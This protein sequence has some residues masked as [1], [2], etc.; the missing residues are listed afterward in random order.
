MIMLNIIRS[1]LDRNLLGLTTCPVTKLRKNL[2]QIWALILEYWQSC[3]CSDVLHLD[4]N[5]LGLRTCPVTKLRKHLGQIWALIL[6]YRQSCCCS[7][8]LPFNL[9]LIICTIAV[10]IL[11][12]SF[13]PGLHMVG[14][15]A[16]HAYDDA[17]KRILMLPTYS[18]KIFLANYQNL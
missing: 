5:L 16:E 13:K 18:L 2:G 6:E 12:T 14:K 9:F 1:H 17:L 11:K 7:D 15:I 10:F 4:R 3:C 8:V